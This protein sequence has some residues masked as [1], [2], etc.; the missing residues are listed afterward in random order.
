M[1]VSS[2]TGVSNYSNTTD[3]R[4]F[5]V[6]AIKSGDDSIGG[7]GVSVLFSGEDGPG[8]HILTQSLNFITSEDGDQFITQT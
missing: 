6:S 4:A 3:G 7:L 8:N 1:G 2:N 5:G